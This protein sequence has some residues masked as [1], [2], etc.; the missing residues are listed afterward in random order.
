MKEMKK[1]LIQTINVGTGVA[2][3]GC[4]EQYS[5]NDKRTGGLM[6]G[7]SAYGPCCENRIMESIKRYKEEQYITARCPKDKSFRNWVLED[8][9]GGENGKIEIFKF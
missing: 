9:R 1:K 3:D 7:S 6:L 2:C 4:G 8:L 5:P